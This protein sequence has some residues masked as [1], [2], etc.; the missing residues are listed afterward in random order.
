M[1]S[2]QM[3]PDDEKEQMLARMAQLES[4]L[5]RLGGNIPGATPN[6][7]TPR[8]VARFVQCF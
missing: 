8:N 5:E 2:A 4:E 1:D 7:S 3:S 6:I